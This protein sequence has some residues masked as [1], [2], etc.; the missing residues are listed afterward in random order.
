MS[1]L[2][3]V[4]PA[5]GVETNVYTVPP[6]KKAVVNVTIMDINTTV[7]SG[8]VSFGVQEVSGAFALKDYLLYDRKFEQNGDIFQITGLVLT[9]GN[10]LRALS[11]SGTHNFHV[12]GILESV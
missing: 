2:T 7:T 12:N 6:G 10:N 8:S 3:S 9:S 4:R 1:L 5:A 11:T